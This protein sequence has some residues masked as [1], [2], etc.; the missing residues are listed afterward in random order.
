MDLVMACSSDH[1]LYAH[2]H[3]GT[4]GS[5]FECLLELLC[6]QLREREFGSCLCPY[7]SGVGLKNKEVYTLPMTLYL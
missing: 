3:Q 5:V 4:R 1:Q 6:K 7:D 2:R